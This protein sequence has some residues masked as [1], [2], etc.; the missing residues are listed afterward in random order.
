MTDLE[1]LTK[2]PWNELGSTTPQLL[3]TDYKGDRKFGDYCNI[4]KERWF[5]WLKEKELY[6]D[7]DAKIIYIKSSNNDL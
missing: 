7:V 2:K 4:K 3:N 1:K 5:F 6:N